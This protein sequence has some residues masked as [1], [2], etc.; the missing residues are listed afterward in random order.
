L[1]GESYEIIKGAYLKDILLQPE[2][3][4]DTL[5]GLQ[6]TPDLAKLGRQLQKTDFRLVVLTGMGSSY[7]CL[8]PINIE[9]T[10]HG[11]TSIMVE[12]SELLYYSHQLLDP[13]TFLLAVSQS[14]QSAE[15]VRLLEINQKRATLLGLTNTSDSPMAKGCDTTVLTQAGDEHSVS[16]KTYVTALMALKWLG[17]LLCGRDLSQTKG[18]LELVA[19]AVAVY[20]KNWERHVATLAEE[21]QEVQQ[22][23]LVG[24]GSSLA[25]VGTGGLIVKESDH[26]PAEG[27][28]SAS[29]R[30]GPMEMLNKNMYVLVFSGEAT[31][32]ALNRSLLEDIRAQG[33][34][35]GWV[36]EDAT[37]DPF[38]LPNV[39]AN[40]LPIVEI[41]VVEMV[42]LALAAL[43]GR[44]A[45]RFER[46]TKVTTKE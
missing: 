15:I 2:A 9:L 5:K 6:V 18:E 28:S 10:R 26:F 22:L 35:A 38:R 39:P 44:E 19:P 45:G 32:R 21:L 24:R 40:L 29:F 1:R 41:L 23:F 12:T 3:L 43:Q 33:G 46:A 36:G 13:R 4:Q 37:R 31:T 14:G 25:T 8:H 42:T 7:H 34:R 20:L 11:L 27:M 16:C 17:D 30:H